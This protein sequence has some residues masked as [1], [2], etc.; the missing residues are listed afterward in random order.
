VNLRYPNPFTFPTP[1]GRKEALKCI[2]LEAQQ[3]THLLEPRKKKPSNFWTE[4][5]A[6]KDSWIVSI[7][8]KKDG[9]QYKPWI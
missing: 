6:S 4:N 9:R 7:E 2:R 8:V 5:V 1:E 3:V